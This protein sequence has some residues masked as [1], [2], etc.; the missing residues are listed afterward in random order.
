MAINRTYTHANLPKSCI[1][2]YQTCYKVVLKTL[3]KTSGVGGTKAGYSE[4][5]Q[6]P[7]KGIKSSDTKNI[8]LARDIK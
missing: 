4:F 1:S 3:I 8:D 5:F 2:E 7:Q 6:L